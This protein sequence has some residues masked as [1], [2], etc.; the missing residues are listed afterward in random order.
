MKKGFTTLLISAL[1]IWAI[2]FN[3][4][5]ETVQ[6]VITIDSIQ[7]E[8]DGTITVQFS[9]SSEYDITELRI[10]EGTLTKKD[11]DS[12]TPLN[13]GVVSGLADGKYTLFAKD[14]SGN[15][16]AYPFVAKSS[17]DAKQSS[18]E[19]SS[20]WEESSSFEYGGS[21]VEYSYEA[22]PETKPKGTVR[23]ETVKETTKAPKTTAAEETPAPE[24]VQTGGIFESRMLMALTVLFLLIIGIGMAIIGKRKER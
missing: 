20:E 15:V 10:G 16:G 23:R 2:A 14:S 17:A 19:H 18:N 1:M 24:L 6:P 11:F 13:G 21:H 8:A 7:R 22:V 3:S 12:A 5:A 9:A 4:L